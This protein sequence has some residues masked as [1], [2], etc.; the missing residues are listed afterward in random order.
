MSRIWNYTP[1]YESELAIAENELSSALE[2]LEQSSNIVAAYENIIESSDNF[3]LIR[4]A[5]EKVKE[6]NK[7]SSKNI[8]EKFK[9]FLKKIKEWFAN[10]AREF[11]TKMKYSSDLFIK[12]KDKITK[13][14]IYT[15]VDI[16]KIPVVINGFTK[17]FNRVQIKQDD[18]K[19]DFHHEGKINSDV[20]LKYLCVDFGMKENFAEK[21]EYSISI[22]GFVS[23]IL[24]NT[25]ANFYGEKKS[26]YLD[27]HSRENKSNVEFE[28]SGKF[29][30][31][32]EVLKSF[33][34]LEKE[35][36]SMVDAKISE[37]EALISN[38]HNIERTFSSIINHREKLWVVE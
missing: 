36:R 25:E 33:E 20:I 18:I 27:G 1:S 34:K 8:I 3:E 10:K 37:L 14:K 6:E 31:K 13:G 35:L 30:F 9:N 15:M 19:L 2:S 29:P 24:T 32:I 11:S 38:S 22:I 21:R 4:E 16:N 28:R 5:E 26:S 23:A 12:N 17:F 7:K